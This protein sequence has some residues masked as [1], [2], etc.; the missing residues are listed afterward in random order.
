MN[1]A[2]CPLCGS[3]G[4]EKCFSERHHDL[5]S[6]HHCGLFF[7]DPY[8]SD[9]H[10][11]VSTY[12]YDELRITD[13]ATHHAASKNYYRRRYW[14]AIKSECSTAKS[15]LDVGCGTG[16]LLELLG[17]EKPDMQ[18]V[19]IELNIERA[20]FARKVAACE[21]HQVPVEEFSCDSKFDIISMIDVLSHIPSIDSLFV[22]IRKLLAPQGKLIL[23]V[24]E[25]ASDVKK[26]SSF[27]WGIPDHLH[28]LGVETVGYICRKYG[29]KIVRHDR[30]PY[31]EDLF[32]RSY[33][34]SPGRSHIRNLAKRTIALTPFALFVLRKLYD[35]THG[36]KIYSSFIVVSPAGY[37]A[38]S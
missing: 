20:R 3:Q 17:D 12:D 11:R 36:A 15:I 24:G 1:H 16:T 7:I 30:R 26:D 6:C 38:R 18:R 27:D 10:E 8:G 9:V 34:L 23:K 2:V 37:T 35:I 31:S 29:F 28:F 5:L 33:W 14:S 19:G 4:S 13:P 21:I 22:S 32:S 25:M